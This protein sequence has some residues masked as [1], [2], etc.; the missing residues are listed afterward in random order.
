MGVPREVATASVTAPFYVAIAV[1]TAATGCAASEEPEPVAQRS[2]PVV[3][4]VPGYGGSTSDL[5]LIAAALEDDGREVRLVELDPDWPDFDSQAALL[6]AAVGSV[7]EV[8]VVGF[9]AGGLVAR[10]W[11]ADGGTDAARRIVTVATPNHG[12]SPDVLGDACT[13]G[14]ASLLAGSDLVTDL[15]TGDET[16][17]GSEWATVWSETDGV[18]VPATSARLEGALDVPVQDVCPGLTPIHLEM[19]T[20]P[21]PAMVVAL[22]GGEQPELPDGSVCEAP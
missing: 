2:E 20:A 4:L 1:L 11:A 18:V 21:I 3:L 15:N 9:S 5:A 13:G 16:P 6:D 7:D 8:D 19:L 14:C 17:S 22:L 10:V 12:T